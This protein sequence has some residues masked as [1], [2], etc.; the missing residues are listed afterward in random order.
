MVKNIFKKVKDGCKKFK[1]AISATMMAIVNAVVFA[2]ILCPIPVYAD[3]KGDSSYLKPINNLKI[4]ALAIVGA[5]G[6]IVLIYGIVKFAESFQK[7]DQNGEYAALYTIGAG[8]IL[9]GGSII[10]GILQG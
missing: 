10:L 6:T 1:Q 9:A 7:K 5:F 3:P 2:Y 8:T 4:V